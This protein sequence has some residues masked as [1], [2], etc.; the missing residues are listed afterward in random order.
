MRNSLETGY[1]S[2]YRCSTICTYTETGTAE[3]GICKSKVV[4]KSLSNESFLFTTSKI[5]NN[6][7]Y[8]FC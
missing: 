8:Q 1:N 5:K 2:Q 6:P 3:G 4:E 7:K